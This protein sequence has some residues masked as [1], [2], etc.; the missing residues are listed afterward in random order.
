SATGRER[1]S[2]G[3][4][5]D[6]V[7]TFI[8]TRGDGNTFPGASMPFG[9]AQSSP[10]GS[11]YSGWRYDDPLIRGFGHFFLSGAGCAEQGGLVSILPT[12]GRLGPSFNQRNYGSPFSH[13]GE[14]GVPG[15]YRVRL[16]GYGGITVES[17]ATVR[18]GVE[19]FTCPP[20]GP[21]NG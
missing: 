11:H 2:T 5:V 6:S 20:S 10:I 8:G 21:S 16:T 12:T 9:M 13:E 3:D 19:W 1:M 4:P 15:Y 18:A 14:V 7:N 17:T